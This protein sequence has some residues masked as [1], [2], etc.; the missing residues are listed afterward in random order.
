MLLYKELK[1]N[2][3][4]TGLEITFEYWSEETP[5][6]ISISSV[7]FPRQKKEFSETSI[8]ARIEIRLAGIERKINEIPEVPDY[9]VEEL[10]EELIKKGKMTK[11]E[12]L[13]DYIEKLNGGI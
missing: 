13:R 1:R 11:E 12:S 10:K 9:D 3:R 6:D 2:N 8:R 7:I 4:K 5:E